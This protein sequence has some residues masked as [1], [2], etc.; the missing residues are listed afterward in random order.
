MKEKIT[1]DCLRS[2]ICGDLRKT[3]A[4][5]YF[6]HFL[7]ALVAI[8]T[9][10]GADD[11]P[12]IADQSYFP[13]QKGMF[14]LYDVTETVYTL[15]NP[16]TYTYEL[17]TI[18]SDSFLNGQQN[19]TYVINRF[20]RS[21]ENETWQP[22]D[23]WHTYK[24]EREVVVSEGNTPFVVLTFPLAAKSRWNGNRYN[25]I[26]NP[27]TKTN[28]D[29]YTLERRDDQA[30]LDNGS[31]VKNCIV[32]NQEDNQEFIVFLDQR[33]EIYAAGIG[34]VQK[35]KTGLSYCNDQD[36]DCIGKQIVDEGII[37]KQVLREYGVE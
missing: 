18:V 1:L 31:T 34:L 12:R 26:I 3:K 5:R 19:F 10:C 20:R 27:T 9:S 7:W 4:L 13:L 8:M 35:E 23:T 14:H 37:Y 24:T 2:N 33:K 21:N 36:R 6:R 28:E 32:I 22:L 17:K 29:L 11:T 16:T 30:I 15:G 25:T